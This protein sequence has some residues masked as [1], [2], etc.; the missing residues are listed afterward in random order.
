LEDLLT[1][2]KLVEKTR[3]YSQ[4][5]YTYSSFPRSPISYLQ[6]FPKVFHRKDEGFP[7][8]I[9]GEIATIKVRLKKFTNRQATQKRNKF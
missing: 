9:S 5:I 1:C 6:V 2:G 3:V 4:R 7:Q 8:E